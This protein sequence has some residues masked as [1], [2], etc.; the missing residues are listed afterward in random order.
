MRRRAACVLLALLA[1]APACAK[2]TVAP[3]PAPPAAPPGLVASEPAAFAAHVLDDT[4]LWGQFDRPLDPSSVDTTTVFLKIDTRR[5]PIT[6]EYE[7]FTRRVLVR[8]RL[9][10]ALA[11]TY[12]VEFSPE[13]RDT[14]DVRLGRS[15]YF[16]F[17]T[18][19]LRRPRLDFPAAG[20]PESPYAT[21]GWSV[22]A[23]TGTA[24]TWALY[25]GPDS[26]AVLARAGAPLQGGALATYNPPRPWGRGTRVYWSVTAI[27]AALGDRVDGPVQSFVV[28]GDDA[29]VDSLV[30]GA[31]DWSGTDPQRFQY[32]TLDRVWSG[33]LGLYSAGMRFALANRRSLRLSAARLELHTAPEYA[34]SVAAAVPGLGIYAAQ[35]D[36]SP[37]AARVPGPPAAE[38]LRPLAVARPG[39]EP[40]TVVFSGDTLAAFFEVMARRGGQFGP[41]FHS[42]TAFPYLSGATLGAADRPR[43]VLTYFVPPAALATRAAKAAK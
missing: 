35:A 3:T 38:F 31:Q 41:A 19:S 8:P 7:P 24:V 13:L 32:C 28:Y 11:T 34:D 10:L 27:N 22:T 16:Q 21:L 2:K 1:L 29:P 23:A 36:W 14:G 40:R 37:C 26:V 33:P 17:T 43:L 18:S 25:A 9:T 6:V 4:P 30:L 5:Q 42:P 20:E 12:T 39:N 15:V